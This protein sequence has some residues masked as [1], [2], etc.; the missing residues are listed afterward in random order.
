MC[1][2]PEPNARQ[3]TVIAPCVSAMT[4]PVPRREDPDLG[5]WAVPGPGTWESHRRLRHGI[6][7]TCRGPCA[8]PATLTACQNRPSHGLG[9]LPNGPQHPA[10]GLNSD[11]GQ[12][13]AFQGVR[14][15]REASGP[16]SKTPWRLG[17]LEQSLVFLPESQ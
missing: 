10:G 12:P 6:P 16:G 15:G 7:R 9:D 3:H 5:P 17:G 14:H 11:P 8:A 13:P 1:F 4:L 2:V